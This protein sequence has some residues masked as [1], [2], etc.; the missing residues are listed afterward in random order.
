MDF[1]IPGTNGMDD[2]NAF[3]KEGFT[4]REIR[5]KCIFGWY[6]LISDTPGLGRR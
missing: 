6:P 2:L 1:Y 3:S 5:F 4:P